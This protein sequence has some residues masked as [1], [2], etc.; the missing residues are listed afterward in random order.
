MISVG[1]NAILRERKIPLIAENN[2]IAD[3]CKK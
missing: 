2:P 1:I 3:S